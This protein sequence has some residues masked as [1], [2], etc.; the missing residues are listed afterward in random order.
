VIK[1]IFTAFLIENNQI[2]GKD[3]SRAGVFEA[4]T[5]VKLPALLGR[6]DFSH[7]LRV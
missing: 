5:I 6:Y 3:G 1:I 4:L 2:G 7:N